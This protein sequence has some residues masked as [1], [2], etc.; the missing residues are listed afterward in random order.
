[1]F[2]AGPLATPRKPPAQP[3]LFSGPSRAVMAGVQVKAR[4]GDTPEERLVTTNSV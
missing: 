4:N 3:R 1:M 2:A